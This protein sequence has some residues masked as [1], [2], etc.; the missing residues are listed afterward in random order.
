MTHMIFLA[1][2]FEVQSIVLLWAEL[3]CINIIS[4]LML[5]VREC[6]SSVED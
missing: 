3:Q 2:E 5:F 1:A 4:I 6:R